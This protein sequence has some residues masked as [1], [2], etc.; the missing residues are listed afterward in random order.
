[1]K[2]G[3]NLNNIFL[4][5]DFRKSLHYIIL[6]ETNKYPWK[7]ICQMPVAF[8]WRF[9]LT[10]TVFI[11]VREHFHDGSKVPFILESNALS[12]QSREAPQGRSNVG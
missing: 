10:S 3:K 8:F 4:H 1:M 12:S 11:C 6:N 7:G 9:V 2:I 5:N